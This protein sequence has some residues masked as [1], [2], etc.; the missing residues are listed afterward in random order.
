MDSVNGRSTY[1]VLS[2][3]AEADPIP[4]TGITP[5]LDDLAGKKVGLFCNFKRAAALILRA[6]E[7]GLQERYPSLTTSWYRASGR[8]VIEV[9][10]NGAEKFKEWVAGLD[11]V[12]LSVGD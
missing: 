8:N 6:V 11:G 2:P 9:E 3:W 10:T 1:E 5:R 4:L 7:Q 12:V